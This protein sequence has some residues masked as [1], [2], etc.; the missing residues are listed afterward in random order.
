MKTKTKSALFLA[1]LND[2]KRN[3]EIA[4]KELGVPL[5]LMKKWLNLEAE[6]P[7]E[8]LEKAAQI[9]P[10]NRRDF[11]P[12]IDDMPKG[13]I[14]MSEEESKK[15]ERVLS[16]K[17]VPYYAYRDTAMSRMAPFRP[18]WIEELV[19]VDSSD[20]E[21]KRVS[22]NN[23]HFL[24]QFTY[25][26]GPVNFY[27][28]KNKQRCLAK[29]NTGDSMYITPFVPHTFTNRKNDKGE[30]GLILAL[31]FAGALGG[32]TRVEMSALGKE[33]VK[34]LVLPEVFSSKGSASLLA[35]HM[36]DACV[37]VHELS[38]RS[39]IK[40]QDISDFLQLKSAMNLENLKNLAQSLK[41][42]LKDLLSHD[43]LGTE[44]VH[45]KKSNEVEKWLYQGYEFKQLAFT[46]AMPQIK[47]FEVSVPSHK[48]NSTL[49]TSLFQYGYN[50]GPQAITL[51]WKHNN[52]S[53]SEL[54]QA[55]DSFC[56]KPM[57]QHSFETSLETKV[58]ILRAPG[59]LSGNALMELSTLPEYSLTRV[60]QEN[61]QWYQA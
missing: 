21:D 30:R 56:I 28:I 17:N 57:I 41:I 39:G 42:D 35:Q 54:V 3:D 8:M 7:D 9:W 13:V 25:F 31:T 59:K 16:R 18:E 38:L 29:M 12:I 5:D 60:V 40:P 48:K 36:N 32:D 46:D 33:T 6:I 27:Y 26:V 44:E 14:I 15:T 34:D 43:T 11:E 19:D 23:G 49:I 45:I 52:E 4:A 10:I 53:Y 1:A 51:N 50:L 37:D 55:N 20:P 2:L 47:A 24:H 22:W 61:Q 58:L